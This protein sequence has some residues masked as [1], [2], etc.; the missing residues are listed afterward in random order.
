MNCR[1][2]NCNLQKR[3]QFISWLFISK[4]DT[5]ML[6]RFSQTMRL[7]FPSF[8]TSA[9]DSETDIR[10]IAIIT[11]WII[12]VGNIFA[13]LGGGINAWWWGNA[14]LATG[15]FIG[16]LFGIPKV[17]QESTVSEQQDINSN[18]Y[19]QQVNTN[20]EQISDWITKIIVGFG[21]IQMQKIPDAFQELAEY[22]ASCSYK[23]SPQ[24]AGSLI[25]FFAI[26]GFF[27]GYLLTRLY[28]AA[29]F[30]R[31]DRQ[32]FHT[33]IQRLRDVTE[34]NDVQLPKEVYDIIDISPASAITI[35]FRNFDSSLHKATERL[36]LP[37]QKQTIDAYRQLTQ[38][39]HFNRA[40][41][42]LAK[43][44]RQL[45]NIAVHEGDKSIRKTDAETYIR[46]AAQLTKEIDLLG[47]D[48]DV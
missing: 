44:L 34:D 25:L 19:S 7:L 43:Q 38:H 33:E 18:N 45:R 23:I 16:F 32:N 3:K 36:G 17:V 42:D 6:K 9:K 47:Q 48:E 10:R 4:K 37:I 27:V 28:L 30:S 11:F 41:L 12:I 15:G 2:E 39:G 1:N 35:A 31:A 40:Q 29:A 14:S 22:V 20:L 21:L 46:N 26:I 24:F 8:F 5:V 13:W